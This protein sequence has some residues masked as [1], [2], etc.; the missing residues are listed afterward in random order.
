VRFK[1]FDKVSTFAATTAA[2]DPL[3]FSPQNAPVHPPKLHKLPANY[4][5]KM[6]NLAN[7]KGVFSHPLYHLTGFEFVPSLLLQEG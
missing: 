4:T 2:A 1:T 5:V 3:E 7:Q 6:K